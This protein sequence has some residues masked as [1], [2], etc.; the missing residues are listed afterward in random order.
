MVA[1]LAPPK[2]GWTEGTFAQGQAADDYEGE[3][4]A[5]SYIGRGSFA[6]VDYGRK[7]RDRGRDDRDRGAER[8]GFHETR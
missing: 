4:Y 2:N 8:H 7:G 5:T 3:D 6:H 1:V